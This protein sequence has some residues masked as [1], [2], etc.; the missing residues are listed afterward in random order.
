VSEFPNLLPKEVPG[1]PLERHIEF[2]IELLLGTTS[3]LK[4]AYSAYVAKMEESKKYID[5]LLEKQFIRPSTS[6][7]VAP[8]FFMEK[9]DDTQ[10][11]CIDCRA[12][13][14]V[15]SKIKYPLPQIDNLFD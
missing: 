14:V 7:W 13:N 5:E 6:P 15:T 2:L 12:L 9:K 8:M 10:Q 3:T 4:R 1:M 11:M